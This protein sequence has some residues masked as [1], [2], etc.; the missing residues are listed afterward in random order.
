MFMDLCGRRGAWTVLLLWCIN[1]SAADLTCPQ[2][3]NCYLDT[4]EVNCSSRHLTGVPEGLPNNAKRLDLS[5]N[6][7]KTL[8]RRQ[9][10]SLSKLEDLDLSDNIIS[11]IEV[12]TF[13]GLKNLRYLRIKNNRLKILPVGG[14]LWSLQPSTS[15]YQ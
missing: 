7:L 1:L 4:L 9:F 10:S 2:K 3:C 12:E 11:M 6:Q 15:G 8:A 5:R 13:Q 14:L